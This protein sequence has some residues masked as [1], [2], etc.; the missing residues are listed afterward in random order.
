MKGPLQKALEQSLGDL[1]RYL[2]RQVFKKKLREAGINPTRKLLNKLVQHVL[3][4]GEDA[5]TWQG[6]R[7]GQEGQLVLTISDDDLEELDRTAQKFLDEDL[8]KLIEKV[9]TSSAKSMLSTL[10]ATWPDQHAWELELYSGFRE[11]LEARWKEPLDLLRMILAISRELGEDAYR[12]YRRSRAKRGRHTQGV[13]IQLHARACQV[14]AEIITLLE[15]GYADGAI[16]R[17]RTLYEID[18]VATLIAEHGD[19][20]AERYLAHEIVASERALRLYKETANDLG[21]RPP[22]KKEIER[23]ERLYKAALSR[24]GP[25]FGKNYGW[26][27]KHLNHRDPQILHLQKAAGRSSMRSHYKMAS[28]NVHAGVKGI[29]F[30]LSAPGRSAVVAGASNAGL[31]EP[32]QNAVITLTKVT[33][34]LFGRRRGMDEL[35]TMKILVRLQNE[36]VDAFVKTGRQLAN[37]EARLRKRDNT[38]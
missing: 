10:K 28:D 32:G 5:F 3:D 23:I 14:A 25:E 6:G 38:R 19:D 16:A 8:P 26:A 22:A 31:D 1:P 36:A 21:Y 9:S 7:G 34:L 37:D 20:L 27:A 12:R 33:F 24:Y 13:L 2:A 35:V 4:G 18:V 30:K 29:L 15:A 17:W 11:R